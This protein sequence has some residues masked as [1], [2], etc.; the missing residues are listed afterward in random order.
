[1]SPTV[2]SVVA[3]YEEALLQEDY[4]RLS[5]IVH[6]LLQMLLLGDKKV[7]KSARETADAILVIREAHR[8]IDP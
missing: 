8:A 6:S 3:E 1:M 4:A 2:D 7:R 5:G